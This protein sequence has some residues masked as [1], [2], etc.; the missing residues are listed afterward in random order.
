[1]RHP[2]V[3][4]QLPAHPCADSRTTR[5]LAAVCSAMM[6]AMSVTASGLPFQS[7][8][9]TTTG[10]QQS[11]P[12]TPSQRPIPRR[13]IGPSKGD[14]KEKAQP[15]APALPLPNP[16]AKPR[17]RAEDPL[18]SA[19][20]ADPLKPAS[21]PTS[22]PAPP[23]ERVLGSSDL[24][25]EYLNLASF[26]IRLRAPKG[27]RLT[28]PIV[29]EMPIYSIDDRASPPRFRMQVQALV[30][31]LAT[32]TPAKQV[33]EYLRSMK[34]R[35]QMFTVL[36]N[37]PWT[38]ARVPAH[39]LLTS[40]DLGD[41]LIAVQGWLIL[42]TGEFDFVVVTIL[43]SGVDFG[44][45]RPLLEASFRTIE[46]ADMERVANERRAQLAAG[47][48]MLTALTPERLR[49]LCGTP[50]R[51][52]RVWRK[53]EN[54]SEQELGYYTITVLAG[55][56][57][58]ASC[59]R[60]PSVPKDPTGLLVV[61][62]GR[63]LVDAATQRVSDLEARFWSAWDH[64]SE[65]WTSRVT[66]RGGKLP[67]RSIAQTGIR[68]ERNEGNPMQLLT[69]VL[70][71][72][73][74]RMRDEQQW[75]VPVGVYMPQAVSLVLGELLPRAEDASPLDFSTYCFDPSL[76][77]MPQRTDSFT[78]MED[79]R[80]MLV[81]QPGLDEPATTTW[82]DASGKRVKRTEPGDITT[83]LCLPRQLQ[84]IW[85]QKGLPQQ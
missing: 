7:S 23:T 37:E 49:A 34:D 70:A 42:Q 10:S 83:E 71:N 55:V 27:S 30:S 11:P 33:D 76:L 53:G 65:A 81:T 8:D 59:D 72:K 82:F 64:G 31:A 61:M 1:M 62:Q 46:L 18:P 84:E 4:T 56:M 26:G 16:D 6:V 14:S 68:G 35:G 22:K 17:T 41:G 44:G 43:S 80:W 24:D 19:P 67:D 36:A 47:N 57:S 28:K 39:Y 52:Y 79:G 73:E 3:N 78:R 5:V 50:P 38:S 32:P 15:A 77:S 51:L 63:T 21:K 85:R 69:V 20:K 66:E 9:S 29:G 58:D 13:D 40:T 2:S 48:A 75:T 74:S 12:S 54:G 45:V 25:A 60:P